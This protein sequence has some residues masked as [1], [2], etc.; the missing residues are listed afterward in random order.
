MNIIENH[1]LLTVR[2]SAY[3]KTTDLFS[4]FNSSDLD[5]SSD[6]LTLI[7]KYDRLFLKDFFVLCIRINGRY[8]NYSIGFLVRRTMWEDRNRAK[9]CKYS[10]LMTE[11]KNDLYGKTFTAGCSIHVIQDI[12]EIV[13]TY[14]SKGKD[15]KGII[16]TF[17][18]IVLYAQDSFLRDYPGAGTEY[19]ET[20]TYVIEK[21]VVSKIQL[22]WDD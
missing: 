3:K 5:F 9:K 18:G 6:S 4:K 15:P 22:V 12:I 17:P 21:I 11:L 19:G 16:L 20:K 1:Q 2:L 14:V 7:Y 8:Q 10:Y 13:N